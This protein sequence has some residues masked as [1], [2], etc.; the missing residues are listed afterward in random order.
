MHLL[1]DLS[2]KPP[3]HHIHRTLQ[4]FSYSGSR[5]LHTTA[6]ETFTSC[7]D[8]LTHP[9]ILE[10]TRLQGP[11]DTWRKSPS[12]R[13][14]ADYGN[15]QFNWP[16][17]GGVEDVIF[18]RRSPPTKAPPDWIAQ[19]DLKT[20]C[21]HQI[22]CHDFLPPTTSFRPV[23]QCHHIIRAFPAYSLW[24]SHPS[25]P[26]PVDPGVPHLPH[27]HVCPLRAQHQAQP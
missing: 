1:E 23:F 15:W 21:I 20:S 16:L 5:F 14:G 19:S 11:W 7:Q 24:N 25:S 18:Q 10:I 22:Y 3:H 9:A 13:K 27:L 8:T 26:S 17:R 12:E 6:E 4:K 2:V